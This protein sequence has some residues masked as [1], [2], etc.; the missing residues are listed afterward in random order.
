MRVSKDT[1]MKSDTGNW[2]QGQHRVRINSVGAAVL[3]HL[4]NVWQNPLQYCKVTSL[5]LM[6]INGKNKKDFKEEKKNL[7]KVTNIKYWNH[8]PIQT[9]TCIILGFLGGSAVKNLPANARTT[10]LISGSGRSPG[11]G[12][13]KPFQ[14]SCQDNP[15][16]KRSLAGYSPWG[17]KE[18]NMAEATEH[19]HT[20]PYIMEM[21]WHTI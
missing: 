4:C 15:M 21:L 19:A 11:E 13:G 9:D 8:T 7:W 18:S 2:L 16:D 3:K 6:K 14:Y 12:T 10:G 17:C 20:L 5:Q 1:K